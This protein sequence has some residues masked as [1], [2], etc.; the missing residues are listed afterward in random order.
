MVKNKRNNKITILFLSFQYCSVFIEECELTLCRDV[1]NR[2][3]NMFV[4][5]MRMGFDRKFYSESL[6]LA[7]KISIRGKLGCCFRLNGLRSQ[8]V[9]LII[10]DK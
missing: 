6:V 4:R 8:C 5:E 1:S 2:K 3:L 7:S 10:N 9:Y